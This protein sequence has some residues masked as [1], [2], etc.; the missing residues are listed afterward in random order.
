ME[1]IGHTVWKNRA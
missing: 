1:A